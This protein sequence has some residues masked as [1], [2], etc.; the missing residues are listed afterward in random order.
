M[1][2]AAR[3]APHDVFRAVIR[4]PPPQAAGS[5]G[6]RQCR[7]FLQES[8]RAGMAQAE[9]LLAAWPAMPV[10]RGFRR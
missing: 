2:I 9:A 6:A 5:R 4:D 7:Q 8:D 10:P 1:G 3:R